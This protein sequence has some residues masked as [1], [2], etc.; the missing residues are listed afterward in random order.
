MK[1]VVLGG[2][3]VGRPMALDLAQ[4]EDIEVTVVDNRADVLATLA[5]GARR[6]G[7]ISTDLGWRTPQP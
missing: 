7:W 3:L 5:S 2:G 4:D 6:W 1:V